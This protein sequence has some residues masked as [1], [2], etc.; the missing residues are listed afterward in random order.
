MAEAATLAA[1]VGGIVTNVGILVAFR[2]SLEHR[3]TRL[4]TLVKG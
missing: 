4:E 3:L 1:V 2:V